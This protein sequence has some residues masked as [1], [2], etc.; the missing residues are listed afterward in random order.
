MN[1][2]QVRDAISAGLD[3]EDPGTEPARVERHLAGC[4]E[5]RAFADSA[6][7][8]HR[9]LRVGPAPAIPDLAPGIL[10]AIGEDSS[11]RHTR[12]TELVLRW[13]LVAVAVVQIA[14]AVPALVLGD[15]AGLSVHTAR[16]IGSFDIALAVGF[17]YAAWRP[18]RV[19]GF[20]PVVTALV[21]CLFLS[22]ALD[23]AAGNTAAFGE[24]QHVTDVAGLALVWLLSGE[25]RRARPPSTARSA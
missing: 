17:L 1:C 8:L 23:V 24:V 13:L 20:L 16:H 3:R 25:A 15:G 7:E 5:C 21:V 4:V 9:V 6:E 10:T 12:D 19:A 18:G 2:M 14:I 22:S 11:A